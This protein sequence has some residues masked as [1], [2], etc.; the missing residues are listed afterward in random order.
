MCHIQITEL[1]DGIGPAYQVNIVIITNQEDNGIKV[2][3]AVRRFT[4]LI[5][6]VQI[7]N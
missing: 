5:I 3:I 1:T 4:M 6:L 2:F 7:N